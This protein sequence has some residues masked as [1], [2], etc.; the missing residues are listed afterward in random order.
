M[1]IHNLSLWYEQWHSILTCTH[2]EL[3]FFP[4]SYPHD[5][6]ISHL[7]LTATN[8]QLGLAE[9]W[10]CYHNLPVIPRFLNVT[11]V[12]LA[13]TLLCSFLQS[14]RFFVLTSHLSGAL[15]N[16]CLK[17]GEWTCP[18][19][20][21]QCTILCACV[22]V[23]ISEMVFY[24]LLYVVGLCRQIQMTGKC[25]KKNVTLNLKHY[26]DYLLSSRAWVG[27]FL[28]YI[29]LWTT[30]WHYDFKRRP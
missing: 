5:T 26:A 1:L 12:I 30:M 11:V 25:Q 14:C 6:G 7:N 29:T 9:N 19:N 27:F 18:S 13:F 4:P 20:T 21:Q 15:H 22:C 3:L 2:C 23:S 8:I 24:N 28:L 17:L 16:H 10:L